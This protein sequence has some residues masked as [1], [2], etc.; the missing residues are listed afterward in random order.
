M[1]FSLIKWSIDLR[2]IWLRCQARIDPYWTCMD[3]FN[4]TYP[5]LTLPMLFKL[6][7]CPWLGVPLPYITRKKNWFPH[8]QLLLGYLKTMVSHRRRKS[9]LTFIIKRISRQWYVGPLAVV[10][11]HPHFCPCPHI[12]KWNLATTLSNVKYNWPFISGPKSTVAKC[13]VTYR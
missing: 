6:W 2:D 7:T 10:A 9:Q 8:G 11:N 1:C 12:N 5:Q 3:R 4:L 13:K